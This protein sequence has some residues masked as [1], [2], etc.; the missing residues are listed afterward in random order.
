MSETP[1]VRE[2]R[3]RAVASGA[4]G[5]LYIYDEIG[6]WGITAASVVSALAQLSKDGVKALDIY[7]NSPGGDVFDGMAIYTALRRFPGEKVVHVDGVAASMASVVAMAGDKIITSSGA[8]WMIHEAWGMVAGSADEL[9]ARAALLET[10][11]ASMLDTYQR[12]TKQSSSD[13]SKWMA[14]ETWMTAA[15]AMARGFTD[16]V[17]APPAASAV[18]ASKDFPVLAKFRAVPEGARALLGCAL[19]AAT[20]RVTPLPAAP[21]KEHP[22]SEPVPTPAPAVASASVSMTPAELE[23]MLARASA[24]GAK[25]AMSAVVTDPSA[26]AVAAASEPTKPVQAAFI[27]K[28]SAPRASLGREKRTDESAKPG[29]RRGLQMARTML[30]LARRNEIGPECSMAE[31]ADMLGFRATAER[32]H[33]QGA[34]MSEGDAAAGG[35][36]VP[37]DFQ[38]GFIDSLE[39]VV[40][41]R[42]L[43]GAAQIIRSS[44]EQIQIPRLTAGLTGA[45]VGENPTT[46]SPEALA[47]GALTLRAHKMRI[48]VLVSRDLLRDAVSNIDQIVFSKLAL[49]AG[50]MEDLAIVEGTG[51]EYQ[52]RGL[53]SY[54]G[55]A[56][57]AQTADKTYENARADLRKL[58][59]KLATNK[60]DPSLGRAF[61]ISEQARWGLGDLSNAVGEY[62]LGKE[63]DG[64]RLLGMPVASTTQTSVSGANHCAYAFAPGAAIIFDQLAM[65]VENDSTYTDANGLAKSASGAD[66]TVLRLW[67]RMDF[68]MTHAEAVQ[69]LS[70]CTW[71]A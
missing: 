33:A 63:L 55:A 38:S 66:Q 64:G 5:S 25:S 2:P 50:Q 26:K 28:F 59:K 49:R 37:T 22:V 60:I 29:H 20:S 30:A 42:P 71:G 13:L 45:W 6:M 27:T 7:I 41:I 17:D 54:A 53:K 14:A 34:A 36:F 18:L 57:A 44:R 39:D 70:T 9:R 65:Q 61:I 46:G 40:T 47:T 58:M 67:R 10:L 24:A 21:Q 51:G 19:P 4:R 11:S 56:L 62:P 48:E 35:S 3:F 32:L 68:G 52:P 69:Y 23:A 12:R 31:A 8:L 43:L 15:E 1:A 16:T